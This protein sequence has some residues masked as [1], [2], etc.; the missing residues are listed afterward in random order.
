MGRLPTALMAAVPL[1][2]VVGLAGCFG[3]G[4]GTRS[5]TTALAS[6]TTAVSAP[7]SSATT[8]ARA[9]CQEYAAAVAT[10][11]TGVAYPDLFEADAEA[12]Q[13]EKFSAEWSNLAST[14][15]TVKSEIQSIDSLQSGG[16]SSYANAAPLSQAE[17]TL[18]G[19]L[20]AVQLLCTADRI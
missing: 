1:V 20:T 8:L 5:A 14:F 11:N 19:D 9:A 15:D 4:G 12:D 16:S 18:R 6:P 2:A 7:P 10:T 17:G 13:A 3:G